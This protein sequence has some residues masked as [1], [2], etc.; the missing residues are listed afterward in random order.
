MFAINCCYKVDILVSA[1][2][3]SL[4]YFSL[5]FFQLNYLI[6]KGPLFI[7]KNHKVI[8]LIIIWFYIHSLNFFKNL[9]T[10]ISV[11]DCFK[12]FTLLLWR[13]LTASLTLIFFSTFFFWTM[14]WISCQSNLYKRLSE[15]KQVEW[16]VLQLNWKSDCV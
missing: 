9:N 4:Q 15:L 16:I 10:D 8:F 11:L 1:Y 7:F 12:G 3:S 13:I 2:F 6:S 5:I 14:S